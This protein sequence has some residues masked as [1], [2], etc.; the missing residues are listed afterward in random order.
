[1]LAGVNEAIIAG[2][3][4]AATIAGTLIGVALG[5]RLERERQDQVL[6][7]EAAEQVIATSLETLVQLK[8]IDVQLAGGPVAEPLRPEFA[9]DAFAPIARVAIIGTP[10]D[11]SLVQAI[12]DAMQ[13]AIV[14]LSTPTS[15]AGDRGSA[16]DAATKAVIRFRDH[17]AGQASR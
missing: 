5:N 2:L 1:M 7:R 12:G 17:A 10:D 6:H 4:F 3:G 14:I 13:E 16:I 15:T 8:L 9:R 11:R